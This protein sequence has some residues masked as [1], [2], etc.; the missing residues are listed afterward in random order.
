MR[1]ARFDF[2]DRA[3]EARVVVLLDARRTFKGVG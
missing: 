3:I 1:T 2:F